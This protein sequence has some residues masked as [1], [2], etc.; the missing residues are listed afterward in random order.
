MSAE[1]LIRL[2]E[3]G[4]LHGLMLAVSREWARRYHPEIPSF[5]LVG[6]GGPGRKPLLYPLISSGE[7]SPIVVEPPSVRPPR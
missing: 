5:S 6:S 7:T 1:E 3:R 4:D 2:F